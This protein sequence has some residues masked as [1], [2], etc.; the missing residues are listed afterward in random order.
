MISYWYIYLKKNQTANC[1]HPLFLSR[2]L[3]RE[4]G[5]PYDPLLLSRRYEGKK[6]GLTTMQTFSLT[7]HNQRTLR[8]LRL[9]IKRAGAVPMR[10][11]RDGHGGEVDTKVTYFGV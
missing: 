9:Y 11:P 7:A 10:H 3:R 1:K 4:K 5:R 6:V 2:P 8:Y